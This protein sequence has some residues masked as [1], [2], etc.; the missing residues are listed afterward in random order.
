MRGY[1]HDFKAG[2]KKWASCSQS[3]RKNWE[4][5][6]DTLGTHGECVW[7][8]EMSIWQSCFCTHGEEAVNWGPLL[9]VW[10]LLSLGSW[11]PHDIAAL[12]RPESEAS[13]LKVQPLDQQHRGHLGAWQKSR[14]SAWCQ[15]YQ[16]RIGPVTDP[17]VICEYSKVWEALTLVLQVTALDRLQVL[18]W[19][20]PDLCCVILNKWLNV[21]TPLFA[22]F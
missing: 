10:P 7:R 12:E 5:S 4:C 9:I 13:L 11:V 15:T 1:P 21:S 16:I 17:Q 22:H 6:W 19:D 8:G 20:Q 2:G 3:R 18:I 14:V